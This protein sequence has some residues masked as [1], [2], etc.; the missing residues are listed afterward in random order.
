MQLL[1]TLCAPTLVVQSSAAASICMPDLTC[2]LAVLPANCCSFNQLQGQTCF[3]CIPLSKIRLRTP[4]CTHDQG[5][6]ADHLRALTGLPRLT[7]LNLYHLHWAEDAVELGLGWLAARLPRL[8]ILNAPSDVLVRP[9]CLLAW[10]CAQPRRLLSSR[11][12]C[13]LAIF[14]A[15][16]NNSIS[17]SR[18]L[19][20]LHMRPYACSHAGTDRLTC[21]QV[22]NSHINM[23]G[24]QIWCTT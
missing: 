19:V 3:S 17:I 4:P 24:C 5:I 11:P 21:V 9:W 10:Q 12:H 14:Q 2:K 1:P 23:A 15:G 13:E 8:K 20:L 7:K 22:C 16:M 18:L 6:G